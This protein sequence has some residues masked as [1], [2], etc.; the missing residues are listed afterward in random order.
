MSFSMQLSGRHVGNAA[1]GEVSERHLVRTREHGYQLIL[2]PGDLDASVFVALVRQ[3]RGQPPEQVAATLTT[4]LG[5]CF[6]LPPLTVAHPLRE[7]ASAPADA[8]VARGGAR[9][10]RPA[11]GGRGGNPRSR[12]APTHPQFDGGD[13]DREDLAGRFA[14]PHGHVSE[15]RVRCPR[16]PAPAHPLSTNAAATVVLVVLLGVTDLSVS[17]VATGPAVRFASTAPQ[18]PHWLSRRSTPASPSDLA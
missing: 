5:L 10:R 3:A 1:I 9:S 18:P 6:L 17:P 11:R 2:E 7:V 8:G 4:A 13:V 15:R 12:S 16:R 14:D